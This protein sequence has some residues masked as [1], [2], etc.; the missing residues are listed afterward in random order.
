MFFILRA[1]KEKYLAVVGIL[2]PSTGLTT[3]IGSEIIYGMVDL[4][5]VL[6]YS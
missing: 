1:C 3:T 5:F 4:A 2:K 6:V